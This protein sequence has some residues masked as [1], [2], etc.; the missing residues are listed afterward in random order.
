MTRLMVEDSRKVQATV[1]VLSLLDAG[2]SHAKESL[3]DLNTAS[4]RTRATNSR[5]KLVM[6]MPGLVKLTSCWKMLSGHF[7]CQAK[8]VLY[9]F[10][11]I[12]TPQR[13][14]ERHL[15]SL[16]QMHPGEQFWQGILGGFSF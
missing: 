10:G 12:Q 8:L 14:V 6:V 7:T 2:V 5:S 11:S 4:W 3:M 16:F 15:C 13:P 1:G 9:L